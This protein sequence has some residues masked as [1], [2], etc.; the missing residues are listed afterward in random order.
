[1]TK[2]KEWIQ[3]EDDLPR[4]DEVVLI[5]CSE[6]VKEAIFQRGKNINRKVIEYFC[7][8]YHGQDQEVTFDKITHWMKLPIFPNLLYVPVCDGKYTVIQENTGNVKALRNGK[9]WRDCTGDNLIL[10]LA[11]EVDSLRN[12][13][14]KK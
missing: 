13:T 12:K 9:E 2:E 1:M 14:I 7:A 3:V 11:Q 4:E 5:F 10:T 8:P 6:G